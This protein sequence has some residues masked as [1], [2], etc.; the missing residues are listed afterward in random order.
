M[1]PRNFGASICKIHSEP[2]GFKNIL[3]SFWEIRWTLFSLAKV[4]FEIL[5]SP[6]LFF[7]DF[8]N[9]LRIWKQEAR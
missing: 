2:V 6:Q 3:G 1:T 8:C 7:F 5:K 9:S 4:R